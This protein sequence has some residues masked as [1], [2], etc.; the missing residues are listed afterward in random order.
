MPI[1]NRGTVSQITP[2]KGKSK[3]IFA[4]QKQK[5]VIVEKEAITNVLEGSSTIISM[6]VKAKNK[7][8]RATNSRAIT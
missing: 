5:Q 6:M 3:E 8:Q 1:T 7:E 4:K 2:V